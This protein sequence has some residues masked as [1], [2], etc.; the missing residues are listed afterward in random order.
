MAL[1]QRSA[2]RCLRSYCSGPRRKQHALPKLASWPTTT[3][4]YSS[5]GNSTILAAA[6]RWCG[7]ATK[8]CSAHEASIRPLRLDGAATPVIFVHSN[9]GSQGISPVDPPWFPHGHV[10]DNGDVIKETFCYSQNGSGTDCPTPTCT[11]GPTHC[12]TAKHPTYGPFNTMGLL[13]AVKNVIA[14]GATDLNGEIASSFARATGR[15]REAIL[16]PKGVNQFSTPMTPIANIRTPRC[17]RR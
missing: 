5:D 10:N 16:W 14:V 11:A 9:D 7:G 1:R 2:V 13:S 6:Q 17:H 15:P 3:L 4:G 8:T 12:E